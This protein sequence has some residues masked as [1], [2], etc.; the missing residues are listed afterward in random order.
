MEVDS[1]E[2]T[3]EL[4]SDCLSST[5]THFDSIDVI[6][7][8]NNHH[9][10]HHASMSTSLGSDAA[11]VPSNSTNI[12]VDNLTEKQQ[13]AQLQHNL[14]FLKSDVTKLTIQMTCSILPDDNDLQ[15]K[16]YHVQPNEQKTNNC[17]YIHEN[18]F[19][20]APS[21][22]MTNKSIYVPI[23]IEGIRTWA[24]I[25]CGCSFSSVSIHLTK[26]LNLKINNKT[27]FIKLAHDDHN[28]KQ[29][30]TTCCI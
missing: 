20:I 26:F 3:S 15:F 21:N 29:I 23:S 6:P 8:N 18:D 17:K 14:Q 13:E 28:V 16:V 27:G 11:N 22:I 25:D 24:L 30:G 9:D 10:N 1:T 2:V 4:S 19:K 7:M 12:P 5:N